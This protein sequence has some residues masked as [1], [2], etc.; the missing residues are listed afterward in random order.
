MKESFEE[1]RIQWNRQGC[2]RTELWRTAFRTGSRVDCRVLLLEAPVKKMYHNP[3]NN[4]ITLGMPLL[5]SSMHLHQKNCFV[6]R[7][8]NQ[9]GGPK[10]ALTLFQNPGNR[11]SPVFLLIIWPLSHPRALN[12][13]NYNVMYIQNVSID[14]LPVATKHRSSLPLKSSHKQLSH[15]HVQLQKSQKFYPK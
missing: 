3:T 9:P 1:G 12:S 13:K 11:G 15:H 5:G 2:K 6:G 7:P 10:A 4:V 14:S 8:G